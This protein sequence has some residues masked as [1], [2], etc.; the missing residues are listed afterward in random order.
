MIQFSQLQNVHIHTDTRCNVHERGKRQTQTI[1]SVVGLCASAVTNNSSN[2]CSPSSSPHRR[3]RL[4]YVWLRIVR[5]S[6]RLFSFHHI[7]CGFC[8]RSCEKWGTC[9]VHLIHPFAM[10]IIGMQSFHQSLLLSSS[11]VTTTTTMLLMMMI[12][13]IS[14]RLRRRRRHSRATNISKTRSRERTNC[15]IR[16]AFEP[17]NCFHFTSA[18]IWAAV[19][20]WHVMLCALVFK[21]M[22][23]FRVLSFLFLFAHRCKLKF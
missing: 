11:I 10:Q 3:R 16:V 23:I 1:F 22:N 8:F 20:V 2:R 14:N 13:I 6:H 19:I 4:G 15:R 21:L 9:L 5:F 12:L 7:E 18:S 17:A